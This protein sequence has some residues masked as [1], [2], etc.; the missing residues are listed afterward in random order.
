MENM[1]MEKK[2]EFDEKMR[3]MLREQAVP[4][5]ESYEKRVESVLSQLTEDEVPKKRVVRTNWRVAAAIVAVLLIVTAPAAVAGV[6]TYIAHL[7]QMEP[8]YVEQ[9]GDAIQ[10]SKGEADVYSRKLFPSERER[11]SELREQYKAG[12]SF[13]NQELKQI[14][15]EAERQAGEFCFCYENSTYYLPDSEM[16]EEQ[17]RQIVDF[18]YRRDYVLENAQDAEAASKEPKETVQT[19]AIGKENEPFEQQ[20]ADVL[21][22]LCDINVDG[23][24]CKVAEED[25]KVV[26]TY[27]NKAW[28]YD[29]EVTIDAKD[30]TIL[31]AVVE[32]DEEGEIPEIIPVNETEYR[33]QGKKIREM[34]EILLPSE[35]IKEVVMEYASTKEKMLEFGRV[36]YYVVCRDGS[37]YDFT[38][39]AGTGRISQFTYSSE[40]DK[41]IQDGKRTEASL[42]QAGIKQNR[43]VLEN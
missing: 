17:L 31:D 27:T 34:A 41:C 26:I 14:Q 7:N 13:P 42:R 30:K 25:D 6:R 40:M 16:N 32:N 37:G 23:A 36:T 29:A 8:E 15:T 39:W 2:N 11:I 35:E 19:D 1:G 22:K 24:E 5:P 10:N 12:D 33:R 3:R 21:K 28:D 38:Y 20:V 4:L 9:I 18:Q 43:V